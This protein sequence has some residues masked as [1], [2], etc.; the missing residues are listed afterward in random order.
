MQ[1]E[2]TNK[3]KACTVVSRI[4]MSDATHLTNFASDKKAWSVYMT[5]GNLPAPP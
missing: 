4:F 1:Y 3:Q 5:I 2:E